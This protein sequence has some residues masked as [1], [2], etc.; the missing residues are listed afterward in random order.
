MQVLRPGTAVTRPEYVKT[1]QGAHPGYAFVTKT[2]EFAP[3]VKDHS[4]ASIEEPEVNKS[5]GVWSRWMACRNQA[6][7]HNE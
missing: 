6:L 7:Q 2:L 3:V 1:F 4:P 5:L